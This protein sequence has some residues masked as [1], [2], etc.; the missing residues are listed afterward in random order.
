M[1]ARRRTPSSPCSSR[2]SRRHMARRAKK[3]PSTDRDRPYT[4]RRSRMK[5]YL[6]YLGAALIALGGCKK[7]E[8][9]SPT[10]A[11]AD[12]PPEELDPPELSTIPSTTPLTTVA[13]KGSTEGSRVV[14]QGAA[15]GTI[16][17]VVLPGGSFCQDA[18]IDTEEP[19]ELKVYAMTGD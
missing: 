9:P 7:D 12:V 16:V 11:D 5:S 2:R 15:S 6:A 1:C 8:I 14:T 19:T 18:P 13:V 3:F 4:I 10:N 17:T